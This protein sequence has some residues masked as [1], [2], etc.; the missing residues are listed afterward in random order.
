MVD[1]YIEVLVKRNSD[2]STRKK[3]LIMRICMA[4]TFLVAFFTAIPLFYLLTIILVLV[5]YFTIVRANVEFEYF[6]M[7][8]ELEIA[9][10]INKSRRKKVITLKDEM[11]QL[12]THADAEEIASFAG[13]KEID[14]SSKDPQDRPF[15]II[16]NHQSVAKKVLIQV[17]AELLRE[18]Q[19][20]MKNKVVTGQ[21][22]RDA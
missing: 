2:E 1:H 3:K 19:L 8:G 21:F 6:Y 5:Y 22:Q 12:V 10:V 14:C 9:K 11:I 7:D 20:R 4:V 17:N 13:L 15:A 18:F 16:C